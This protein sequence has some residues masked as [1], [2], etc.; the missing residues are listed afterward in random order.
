MLSISTFWKQALRRITRTNTPYHYYHERMMSGFSQM[1][2]N[3]P[4]ILEEEKKVS[5]KRKTKHWNEKLASHSEAI[6]KA[7]QEKERSFE[8]LKDETI[9]V[10]KK[11]DEEIEQDDD[12][13]D[14][15]DE[16]DEHWL[17]KKY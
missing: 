8:E 17:I 4:I 15:T 1:S 14:F 9:K 2:D 7:D 6:V 10:I 12:Q 13:N 11:K 16:G 5:L 3:D